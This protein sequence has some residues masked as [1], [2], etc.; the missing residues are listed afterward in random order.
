M[1]KA[2]RNLDVEK[3]EIH[4]HKVSGGHPL[5]APPPSR[6][7]YHHRRLRLP[8]TRIGES[9]R[10]FSTRQAENL[11]K[12]SPCRAADDALVSRLRWI[13]LSPPHNSPGH[14]LSDYWLFGEL[15]VG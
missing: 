10:R 14:A 2:S 8:A 6:V 4:S 13:D 3:P 9:Y 12:R 7:D 1:F 11:T 5:G 15:S